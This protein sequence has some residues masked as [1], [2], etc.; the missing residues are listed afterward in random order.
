[1]KS[2]I[3]R[4]MEKR[5]REITIGIDN[6]EYVKL[7]GLYEKFGFNELLKSTHTDNH[8]IDETGNPTKYDEEYQIFI[9]RLRGEKN[10]RGK[11]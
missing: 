3:T 11:N 10:V 8:Y 5:F 2:V 9:K 7:K 4:I 1:M 6:R